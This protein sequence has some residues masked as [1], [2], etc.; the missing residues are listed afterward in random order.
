MLLVK[1]WISSLIHL[2]GPI[3]EKP[4]VS[5]IAD[6]LL[7]HYV[8]GIQGPTEAKPV[9]ELSQLAASEFPIYASFVSV[10]CEY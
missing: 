8:L 3:T 4:S 2:A 6:P 5:K 1:Y 9:M 10:I 7:S